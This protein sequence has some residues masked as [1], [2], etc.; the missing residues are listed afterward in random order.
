MKKISPISNTTSSNN[1]L[2]NKNSTDT[3]SIIGKKKNPQLD[4]ED[5][6]DNDPWRLEDFIED[7]YI[8]VNNKVQKV[9][10][11]KTMMKSMMEPKQE[12]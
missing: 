3:K 7:S 11:L 2:L 8:E 6:V 4:F 1:A 12:S 9:E 5:K 10:D